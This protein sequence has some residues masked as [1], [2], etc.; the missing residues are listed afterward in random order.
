MLKSDWAIR[1][2]LMHYDFLIV[3]FVLKFFTCVNCTTVV[4]IP[5]D[6]LTNFSMSESHYADI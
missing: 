3:F 5:L 6:I 2:G 4:S 1:H